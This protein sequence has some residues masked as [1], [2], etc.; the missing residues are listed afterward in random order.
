MDELR[1]KFDGRAIG[2]YRQNATANTLASFNHKNSHAT[3]GQRT[4]RSQTG[5]SRTDDQYV[6]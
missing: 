2:L 3:L 6:D 4:R 1:T 5:H